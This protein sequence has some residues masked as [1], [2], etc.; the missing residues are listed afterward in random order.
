VLGT[1]RRP[2]SLAD[3]LP[4]L[5]GQSNVA[6]ALGAFLLGLLSNV[7]ANLLGGWRIGRITGSWIIVLLLA[8]AVVGI[9]DYYRRR[10]PV[11]V[12]EMVEGRPSGKAGLV[13]LLSTLDPRARGAPK[14]CERR[15]AEVMA[16]AERILSPDPARCSESDF[17]ALLGTNLE[18]E[19]RAIEYHL[20]QGTLRHCWVIGTPDET[21]D[22]GKVTKGSAYLGRVL[23]R[24]LD[25]LH[26]GHE[27][28]FS[29]ATEVRSRDYVTL[30]NA[31]DDIFRK[32]DLKAN[33]VIC[34]VTGGLKLMSIGA[35]LACMGEGRTMQYMDARRDWKGDPVPKGEM[36][37]ILVDINPYLVQP[38][39]E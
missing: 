15:T 12:V 18:P 11:P 38:G 34:D 36:A 28:A 35:A 25:H 7:L 37:P 3:F 8:L 9:W 19:L 27:V 10:T 23:Q 5:V 30:W 24:W 33:R 6:F 2:A 32:S 22:K 21:D 16:A 14:Q 4:L 39:P 17:R 20:A 26:P 13:L 29:P 31:V 1:P